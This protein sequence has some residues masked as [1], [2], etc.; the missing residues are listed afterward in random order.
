MG[1]GGTVRRRRS[2]AESDAPAPT[3]LTYPVVAWTVSTLLLW[4]WHT[5]A[6]YDR[7]VSSNAIHGFEHACFVIGY[8]I[9]WWPLIARPEEVGGLHTNAARAGYLLAGAMQSALLCALI[10]FHGSVIYL[11]YLDLPDLAGATSLAVQRL[12]GAIMLFPGAAVFALAAALVIQ[13][14]TSFSPLPPS[15]AATLLR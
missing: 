15:L 8:V 9:Y 2:A 1:N 3:V 5:P 10:M 14:E 13:S 7:A 6:N 12:A 4:I 11:H